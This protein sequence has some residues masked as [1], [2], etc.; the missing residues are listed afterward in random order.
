[1]QCQRIRNGYPAAGTVKYFSATEFRINFFWILLGLFF[2][3][4]VGNT[5]ETDVLM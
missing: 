5:L 4:K 1:M 3:T 2:P